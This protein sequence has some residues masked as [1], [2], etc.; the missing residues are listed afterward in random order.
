MNTIRNNKGIT[1]ISLIITIII[2]LILSGLA[3]SQLTGENK[4]FVRAQE[5]KNRAVNAEIEENTILAHYQDTIDQ[6]NGGKQTGILTDEE[7]AMFKSFFSKNID[8]ATVNI[9]TPNTWEENIEYE[10]SNG[11]YGQ[12]FTGTLSTN[13]TIVKNIGVGAKI[14]NCGGGALS[15][16]N[17]YW[18]VLNTSWESGSDTQ[19]YTFTCWVNPQGEFDIGAGNVI[20][21]ASYDIWILY[22]K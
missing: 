3:T 19:Q 2:L 21:T 10:F 22:T 17:N 8:K 16:V 11:I 5:A 1:L 18:Y 9:M 4:L 12:R 20:K 13:R 15:A 14:I 6:I 7:Y